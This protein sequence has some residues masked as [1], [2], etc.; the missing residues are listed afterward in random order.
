MTR[1]PLSKTTL[2]EAFSEVTLSKVTLSE[3]TALTVQTAEAVLILT[4]E[5]TD[6]K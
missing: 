2:R 6:V 3:V 5:K 1:Y 4:L